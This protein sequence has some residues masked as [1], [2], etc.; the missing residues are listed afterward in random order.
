MI[1]L[2]SQNNLQSFIGQGVVEVGGVKFESLPQTIAWV[3]INLLSGSYHV[4]MDLNRLRDALAS[5]H[6]SDKDL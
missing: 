5:S 1:L 2:Q 4:F 6:L 3:N